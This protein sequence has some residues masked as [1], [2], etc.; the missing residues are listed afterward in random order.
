MRQLDKNML[1]LRM[2]VISRCLH[3]L[4]FLLFLGAGY[5]CI[6]EYTL[7]YLKHSGLRDNQ[8]YY[9]EAYK[10]LH[11]YGVRE[12]M[13]N[14]SPL[15]LKTGQ[16]LFG[17]KGRRDYI[18]PPVFAQ[19][20]VPLV[21]VCSYAQFAVLWHIMDHAALLLMMFFLLKCVGRCNLT[22]GAL[23]LLV[24][25]FFY[26]FR[27]NFFEG[28]INILILL[29]VTLYIYCSLKKKEALGSIFLCLGILFKI[30]PAVFLLYCLAKKRYTT[31]ICTVS[32]LCA[33]AGASIL[34]FGYEP[35]TK[36]LSALF[37]KCA[38]FYPVVHNIGSL[39][40][41]RQ[42]APSDG[43][44]MALSGIFMA[45]VAIASAVLLLRRVR[46]SSEELL[47][48][49]YMV[50]IFNIV[51]P[52]VFI[53]HLVFLVVPITFILLGGI[54]KTMPLLCRI[55]FIVT[56]VIMASGGIY[57]KPYCSYR[58]FMF[59]HYTNLIVFW[60]NLIV[61]MLFIRARHYAAVMPL[62]Q[63]GRLCKS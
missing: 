9:L 51:S 40:Y 58:T 38:F 52:E 50:T 31:V 32:M 36:Y 57:V 41:I 16:Q 13:F 8:T 21:K 62:A 17:V 23:A 43:A 29:L 37:P 5:H 48:N 15:N 26:P 45:F 33:F 2:P 35:W 19:L 56:A 28:Q 10:Y 63:E 11:G 34:L 27:E 30:Y 55:I 54:F 53:L 4:C 3:A 1:S 18:Y 22:G 14:D 6:S 12:L 49:A 60:L 20:L 25:S 24:V 59:M 7:P 39:S 42:Y 47:H 46:S 44:A 61:A